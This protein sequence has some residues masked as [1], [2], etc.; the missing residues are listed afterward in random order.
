MRE[1]KSIPAVLQRRID[2]LKTLDDAYDLLDSI[3]KSNVHAKA[4]I[5]FIQDKINSIEAELEQS[6]AESEHLIDLM[7]DDPVLWT[8][9]RLRFLQG[10]EWEEAAAAVGVTGGSGRMKAYRFFKAHNNLFN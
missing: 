6:V 7:R 9:A 4:E 10:Y 5:Q 1:S 8:I 3:S 2:L